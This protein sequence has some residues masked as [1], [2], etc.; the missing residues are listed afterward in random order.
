MLQFF[1]VF[2]DVNI[3]EEYRLKLPHNANEKLCILSKNAE[4]CSLTKHYISGYVV[5]VCSNTGDGN[6]DHSVKVVSPEFPV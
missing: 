6:S 2:H 5:L 3:F 4:C 1:I